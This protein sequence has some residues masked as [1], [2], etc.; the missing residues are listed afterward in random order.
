MNLTYFSNLT[1]NFYINIFSIFFIFFLDRISKL[2]VIYL[3]DKNIGG[4][5]YSSD[6]LNINL[7]WN[8]GIAFGLFAFEESKF[9]NFLTLFI[10]LVISVLIY[11]L[12]KSNGVKRFALLI[13][14]GGALGNLYD[15]VI[16]F[17]VPDFIDFH[18]GNFHWFTFNIADIFIS[19]G[20]I[21]M[22]I[23]EFIDNNK[24]KINE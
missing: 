23:F 8:E 11:M 22:I 16:Y 20:V 10:S 9:Y 2:Y 7:I 18:I 6:Y 24:D 19:V 15:R 3:H 17:A 14:I 13:I 4:D 5:L 21:F 12:I 1:K